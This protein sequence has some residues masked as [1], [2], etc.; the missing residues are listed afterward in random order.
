MTGRPAPSRERGHALLYVVFFA[1]T[2]GFAAEAFLASFG[3]LL[4]ETVRE[5]ATVAALYVAEGGLARARAALARDPG[6]RGGTVEVGAGRAE[7]RVI[8]VPGR[9]DRRTVRV[10]GLVA[11]SD[12]PGATV[13]R[14]IVAGL[15]LRDGLP[16][17]VFWTEE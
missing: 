1:V 13:E 2:V 16:R 15:A 6:W 3:V 7:V 8:E 5:R 12:A 14:R 11:G 17:L 10:R 4:R 9:P